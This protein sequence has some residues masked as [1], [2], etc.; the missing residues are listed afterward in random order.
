LARVGE[1]VAP[2]YVIVKKRKKRREA[3]TPPTKIQ[4][5]N[6]DWARIRK[7]TTTCGRF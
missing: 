2:W 3:K 6:R 5:Q 4:F 1:T 7:L